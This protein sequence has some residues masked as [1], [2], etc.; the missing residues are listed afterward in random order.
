MI[1]NG[2]YEFFNVEA[3]LQTGQGVYYSRVP[4]SVRS[5]M[6]ETA[7]QS[8]TLSATGAEL[9]FVMN[10][11]CD[12]AT[13][14][15][16]CE[17]EFVTLG[18]YYGEFQGGWQYLGNYGLHEGEN[19][20]RL[21]RPENLERLRQTA[22]ARGDVFS[23]EV[24]RLCIRSGRLRDVRLEGDV[25]PPR[26]G[27]TPE[28]RALFYGSSITHGSLSHLPGSDYATRVCARLGMDRINKGMA[29]CCLLERAMTD[30]LTARSDY[31][32]CVCELGSNFPGG[33]PE[34]FCARVEYL[35]TSYAQAHPD[36]LMFVIDDLIIL[37]EEHEARRAQVRD[38]L[39][40]ISNPHFVYINGRD[41]LPDER[42]L[43]ADF[44]HP[45]VEG[46]LVM[47]ERLLR[48]MKEHGISE[49]EGGYRV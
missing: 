3:L 47:S 36:K 21:T 15:V 25:R 43:S 44:V 30:Y 24:M 42:L 31:E 11:G 28:K 45:S 16:T 6:S 18:L 5:G 41:M 12:E 13:L 34:E 35:L 40:R 26:A 10:E 38:C 4:L 49:R 19:T 29:G 32:F 48:V 17:S 33:L 1:I 20:V 22:T 27:E 7:Q 23:P 9:R 46:H 2:R 14:N 8:A 39:K 37:G